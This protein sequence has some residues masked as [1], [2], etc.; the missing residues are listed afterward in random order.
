MW[1]RFNYVFNTHALRGTHPW[2]P[3]HMKGY[4]YLSLRDMSLSTTLQ[5]K[6]KITLKKKK[7]MWA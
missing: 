4:K 2:L 3:V 6:M 7:E 1:I 5:Y